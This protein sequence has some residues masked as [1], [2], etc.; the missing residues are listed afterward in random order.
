VPS[1]TP[2]SGSCPSRVSRRAAE[3]NHWPTPDRLAIPA[4]PPSQGPVL[5]SFG[6]VVS[7]HPG[8]SLR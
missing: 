6:G 5:R 3:V 7:L 8:L 2:A 1:P 4:G